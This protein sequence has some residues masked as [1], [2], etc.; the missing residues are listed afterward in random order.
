MELEEQRNIIE[1]ALSERMLHHVLTILRQW[2]KEVGTARYEDRIQSLEDN[3][4]C[5]FDY[6]LGNDDADRDEVLGRL[7]HDAYCLADE[8]YGDIRIKRGMSP[9]LNDFNADDTESV[10]RYFATCV[11]LREEDLDWFDEVVHDKSRGATAL[12]LVAALSKNLREVFQEEALCRLIMATDSPSEMVKSQAIM[13]SIMLM[14]QW[15]IRMDFF[16]KVLETFMAYLRDEEATFGALMTMVTMSEANLKRIM[17]DELKELDEMPEELMDFMDKSQLSK[18]SDMVTNSEAEYIRAIVEILP[19]TWVFD[20][21]MYDNERYQEQIAMQYLSIGR[22]NLVWDHIDKAED[23]LVERLRSGEAKPVDYI[24]YGHC[25][26]LRGDRSM[27]YE[28]YREARARLKSARKFME[29]F[30]PDRKALVDKGVPLDDIY[31]IEDQL[32]RL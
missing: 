20:M 1:R 16:Q 31:F 23:W 5:T 12:V 2:T 3:Y 22:M 27:A 8:L 21:I 30:R 13:F 7:S 10:L 24:N 17:V 18:L 26:F 28:N 25:C 6:F 14:A 32:V 11:H 9:E 29:L 4:R 15:D 19:Q